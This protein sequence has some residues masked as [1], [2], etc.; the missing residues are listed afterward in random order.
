MFDIGANRGNVTSFY[1]DYFQKIVCF[2]P[3]EELARYLENR[4][5][6]LGDR[7]R[8]DPRG[9]S[10]QEGERLFN[11][12][13]M[14]TLS[15][16]SADWISHSRFA[17][18]YQWERQ[19]TVQTTTIDAAIAQYGTPGLVKIDV[20]GHELEVLRGLTR[21]LVS[22]AF[23]FEW[24]EEQHETLIEICRM[25]TALGYHNFAFTV[26]AARTPLLS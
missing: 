11:M 6:D 20:E 13:D 17:G 10:D 25:V 18:Q 19:T 1:L 12:S 7:V 23:A 21:L 16:F 22:T 8:I 15:T 2:E 9:L 5:K 26:P 3:N 24:V 4:F 14:D